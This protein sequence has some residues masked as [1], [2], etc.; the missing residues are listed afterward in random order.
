MPLQHTVNS[1]YNGHPG[2]MDFGVV[3]SDVRYNQHIGYT[4]HFRPGG[5]KC[6]LYPMSPYIT[7]NF[8]V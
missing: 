7:E 1:G 4:G 3:I 5:R 8:T 2:D 6:P